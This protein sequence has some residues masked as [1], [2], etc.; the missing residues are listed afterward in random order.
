MNVRSYDEYDRNESIPHKFKV[1]YSVLYLLLCALSSTEGVE[2]KI[3]EC[4][5]GK[6]R[7]KKKQH[8]RGGRQ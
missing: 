3:C 1:N 7:R 6:E 2:D 8:L 4:L 5:S